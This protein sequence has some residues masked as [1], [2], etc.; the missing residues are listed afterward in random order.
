MSRTVF[1]LAFLS[2]SVTAAH[3][4]GQDSAGIAAVVPPTVESATARRDQGDF[5]AAAAM[6]RDVLSREPDNG[7]ALRAL[8]QIL[9]WV[10]DVA[11]A[12]TL[13]E[14]GMRRHPEDTSLQL[15]YATMLVETRSDRRAMEVLQ[16]LLG[17]SDRRARAATLA[18]TLRYWQGDLTGAASS[19]RAA[20]RY[21]STVVDARRQL[22]EIR[23][24]SAPW[25]T[26]RSNF[27]HDD[28]PVDRFGGEAEAG[29][30]LNPLLTFAVRVNPLH[31]RFDESRSATAISVDAGFA[32]YA[33]A[34]RLETRAFAGFVNRSYGGSWTEWTGRGSVKLRLPL[35]LFGEVRG[36]RVPYLATLAS[37]TDS[38]MSENGTAAVGLSSPGGWKGEAG[39]RLERF[40]DANTVRSA[41]AWLLAPVARDE[42]SIFSI[43]YALGTQDSD[44][45]RFDGRYDPYY[46][47]GNVMSHSAI[48]SMAIRASARTTITGHGAYAFKAWEDAPVVS[49]LPGVGNGRRIE[50]VRRGFN[51]WDAHVTVS[52][53]LTDGLSVTASVDGMKTAYYQATTGGVGLTYRFLPRISR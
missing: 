26:L 10:K 7:D 40:P 34:A 45:T 12:A 43:G 30:F 16:P 20:L 23:L 17:I 47:P 9:Y 52:T 35:N 31:F 2:C 3:A 21:D 39:Y 38:I 46:T 49:L 8:A 18:G 11:G 14:E 19:F 27:L 5:A 33:P 6:L 42:E 24:V 22:D 44:E 25:T 29:V 28:Q 48:A 32:H 41:F 13:Y 4:R 1:L 36:E 53:A 50:F 37:L 15:D 51:P